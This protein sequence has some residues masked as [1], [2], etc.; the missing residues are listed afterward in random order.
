MK[1]IYSLF[2]ISYL[3]HFSFASGDK[4]IKV[5]EPGIYSEGTKCNNGP[6]F[7]TSPHFAFY[8][9]VETKGFTAEQDFQIKLPNYAYAKCTYYLPSK[10]EDPEY[11]SCSVN[12]EIYPLKEL[13]I[14]STYVPYEEG[15]DDF[16][17]LNWELIA[18]QKILTEPCYPSYLYSFV[19]N[20]EN[21]VN[22]DPQGYNTITIYGSLNG[23]TPKLRALSS[24]ELNLDFEPYLLVD[25]KLSYARCIYSN[26]GENSSEDFIRCNVIGEKSAEFFPTSGKDTVTQTNVIF[27]GS[28]TGIGLKNCPKTSSSSFLKLGAILLISLLLL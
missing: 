15:K 13:T 12:I 14:P 22:C 24:D 16:D 18:G 25:G 28:V 3:I 2:L 7:Q 26:S 5:I 17:V 4:Y 23:E 9:F 21:E 6:D 27:E 8:F 1:A 10:A 20:T 19:P 11:I